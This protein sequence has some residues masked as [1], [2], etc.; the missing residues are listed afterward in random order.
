MNVLAVEI[1]CGE[2]LATTFV[3]PNVTAISVLTD[4]L[5]RNLACWFETLKPMCSY[6]LL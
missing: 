4:E 2:F 3:T 6:C 5:V 1:D